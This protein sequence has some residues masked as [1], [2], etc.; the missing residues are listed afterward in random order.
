MCSSP[1][2][3]RIIVK[4]STASTP[5]FSSGIGQYYRDKEIV[6]PTEQVSCNQTAVKMPPV[7]EKKTTETHFWFQL[8]QWFKTQLH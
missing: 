3:G 5:V 1:R 7:S 6:E 2:G 8:Q 4:R